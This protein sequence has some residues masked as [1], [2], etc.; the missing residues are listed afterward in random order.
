M[1]NNQEKPSDIE[2]LKQDPGET[3]VT[4][5]PICILDASLAHYRSAIP[6]S[7]ETH[8]LPENDYL[9]QL[10][11]HSSEIRRMELVAFVVTRQFL[12]SFRLD[13][14]NWIKESP[15][16]EV[17]FI[18]LSDE[19]V[20]NAALDPLPDELIH[21]VLPVKVSPSILMDVIRNALYQLELRYERLTLQ[22]RLALSTQEMRRIIRVGQAMS[23]ERDFDK[24]IDLIL[25][26]ARELV[27]AD[28]GSIYV[29][30]SPRGNEKPQYIRF[31][32]SALELNANE[33][34][35]PIDSSSIAGYVALR[36]EPLLIDDVYALSEDEPYRFNFEFDRLH[37]YY[38]RSML[39]IP[40]KNHSGEVIG[41]IQ[42]I[43]GITVIDI[44]VGFVDIHRQTCRQT[45]SQFVAIRAFKFALVVITKGDL[46]IAF[47]I[48]GGFSGNKMYQTTGCVTPKQGTLR[49]SQ[50]FNPFKVEQTESGSRHLADIHFVNIECDR[51]FNVRCKV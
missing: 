50:N 4:L 39:V 20:D 25:Q 26:Q 21:L 41:V 35:L 38:T 7:L 19:E 32:K 11:D 16:R 34:L 47:L 29:T 6:D 37:N 36:G 49:P 42:L 51:T 13:L 3:E 24:L 10:E 23:T 43:A 18:V 8:V 30:E 5:F 28:A 15:L 45:F 46:R 1:R 17:R 31:K 22:S 14:W 48:K 2:P 9:P 40:M 12:E 44:A 27:G 33:F